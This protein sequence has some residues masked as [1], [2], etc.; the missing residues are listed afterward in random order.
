MRSST[1]RVAARFRVDPADRTPERVLTLVAFDAADTGIQ[2]HIGGGG[3]DLGDALR[4]IVGL[5]EQR[6]LTVSISRTF[7][8]VEMPRHSDKRRRARHRQDCDTA[9]IELVDHDRRTHRPGL[10]R[11][12][13][14]RLRQF[15]VVNH[16]E[17]KTIRPSTTWMTSRPV[18]GLSV[19]RGCWI[20]AIGANRD[21]CRYRRQFEGE[22]PQ[23][24]ATCRCACGARAAR[25][26]R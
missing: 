14:G 20:H 5:I 10:T 12:T 23:Y 11:N 16:H 19:I 26:Q 3:R 4:E 2:I 24:F 21:G 1:P 15:K 18:T 17:R 8:L 13:S 7:P 6:R 25:A 9:L 22:V